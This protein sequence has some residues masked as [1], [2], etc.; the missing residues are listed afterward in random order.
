MPVRYRISLSG[1]RLA[2]SIHALSAHLQISDIGPK[3]NTACTYRLY[4]PRCPLYPQKRTCAVHAAMSA[5]GQ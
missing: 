5:L 2:D 3:P 4:P 1:L